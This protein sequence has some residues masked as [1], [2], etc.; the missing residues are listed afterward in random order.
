MCLVDI[1]EWKQAFRFLEFVNCVRS[2]NKRNIMVT[3]CT[4]GVPNGAEAVKYCLQYYS[5]IL[6]NTK[7]GKILE[8]AS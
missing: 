6:K 2:T 8:N 5:I 4:S 7:F 3:D 1:V